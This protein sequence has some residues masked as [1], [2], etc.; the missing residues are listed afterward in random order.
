MS[1]GVRHCIRVWRR[2]NTGTPG[3]MTCSCFPIGSYRL[4]QRLGSIYG[5]LFMI[6]IQLSLAFTGSKWGFIRSVLC[7]MVHGTPEH[8]FWEWCK[9]RGCWDTIA[10][11]AGINLLLR[12]PFT[13]GEWLGQKFNAQVSDHKIKAVIAICAWLIW[14]ARCRLS[15]YSSA[16]SFLDYPLLPSSL[17]WPA[18]R[19]NKLN[20]GSTLLHLNFQEKSLLFLMLAGHLKLIIV[21][22][23][24]LSSL[25]LNIL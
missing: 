20:T 4:L 6:G 21:A 13:T 8:V 3:K 16:Q 17:P 10:L 15:F 5:R 25:A 19:I 7:G 24:S 1:K 14:K 11:F 9:V 12:N 22:L 18:F 23:A 2:H